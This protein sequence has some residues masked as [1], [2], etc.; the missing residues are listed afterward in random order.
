MDTTTSIDLSL[1][2]KPWYMPVTVGAL[3]VKFLYIYMEKNINKI[4]VKNNW[5]DLKIIQ[6][7][8]F[9]DGP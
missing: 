6:H 2:A 7:K 8:Q 1:F 3:F 9:L 4:L 5:P